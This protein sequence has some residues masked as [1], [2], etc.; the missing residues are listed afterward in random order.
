MTLKKDMLLALDEE[1]FQDVMLTGTDHVD[2]PATKAVLAIRSPVFKRMF[3]GGFQ[4]TNGDRVA[5]DYPSLVLK[6]LVKYC[7]SDELDLDM[8]YTDNACDGLT[9]EEAVLMV[10]LRD[11]AN[12]FELPELHLSISNELGESICQKGENMCVCAVLSELFVR[13][14]TEGPL[15]TILVYIL[16]AEPGKCLLPESEW[17]HGVASCSALLLFKILTPSVEPFAAVK[18]IQQWN[19]INSTQASTDDL[20]TLQKMADAVEIDS[21]PSNQLAQIKPCGLF[22]MEKLHQAFVQRGSMEQGV[23]STSVS[24]KAMTRPNQLLVAHIQ[25]AGIESVNGF[26]KDTGN[27]FGINFSKSGLYGDVL[28][29]FELTYTEDKTWQVRVRAQEQTFHQFVLYESCSVEKCN[30]P[31]AAW[32]CRDGKAPTPYIAIGPSIVENDTKKCPSEYCGGA[33]N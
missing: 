9:D 11:A 13:G 15:W 1:V 10:Q 7:Y 8:I 29:I 5:L 18:A 24:L 22:A 33:R 27:L 25:G 26:Y 30:A 31:F 14:E 4:E 2:V 12:Y 20:A 19:Q 28:S 23:E 17:N 3:F 6:V 21:M 16:D 32:H